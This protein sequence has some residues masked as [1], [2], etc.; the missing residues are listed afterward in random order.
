M[1]KQIRIAMGDGGP[2]FLIEGPKE[3]D[4]LELDERAKS[5]SKNWE[6]KKSG[7]GSE[8]KLV[9]L[10]ILRYV[11]GWENL[12][13]GVWGTLIKLELPEGTEM[14]WEVE[15]DGKKKTTTPVPF[16]K[17]NLAFLAKYPSTKFM[18]FYTH[19]QNAIK[20]LGYDERLQE[21]DNLKN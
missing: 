12:T 18:E 17:K 1:E 14:L 21:L 11:I 4:V 8:A 2:K 16:N 15:K 9:E 13:N 6:D 10:F 19:C 7:K 3:A 5:L 20:D